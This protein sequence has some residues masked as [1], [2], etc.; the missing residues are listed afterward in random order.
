[1]TALALSKYHDASSKTKRQAKSTPSVQKYLSC[2]RVGV[3]HGD[4]V[5][6]RDYPL[7]SRSLLAGLASHPYF[8]RSQ[9][10]RHL[11]RP[12]PV[13]AAR[14]YRFHCC[15]ARSP[16]CPGGGQVILCRVSTSSSSSTFFMGHLFIA[17][18]PCYEYL[19]WV[20]PSLDIGAA[21]STCRCCKVLVVN[22]AHHGRCGC[23]AKVCCLGCNTPSP[24]LPSIF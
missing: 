5:A 20:L 21:K 10:L 23:V 6:A 24:E 16:A 2:T 17:E 4:A 14:P 8:R 13:T 3:E 15:Q 1:L 7:R 9:H 19:S 18:M 11:S 12:E 22:L